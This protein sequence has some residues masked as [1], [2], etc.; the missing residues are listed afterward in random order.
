MHIGLGRYGLAA[1]RTRACDSLFSGVK[2]LQPAACLGVPCPALTALS[3]DF[4]GRCLV[5]MVSVVCFLFPHAP[6]LTD[7][8]TN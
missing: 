4:L 2:S 3:R 7:R 8:Y 5:E 1:V 6:Q